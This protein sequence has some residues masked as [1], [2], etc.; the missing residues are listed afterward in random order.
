MTQQQTEVIKMELATLF[1][2][3]GAPEG[4]WIEVP[5]HRPD[6]HKS[7]PNYVFEP[8]LYRKLMMWI[9]GRG[10]KNRNLF[11]M[12]EAGV[13]KTSVLLEICYRLGIPVFSLSCSGDTK[14]RHLVGT[15][16]LKPDGSSAFVDGPLTQAL[17]CGGVFIGNEMT[18]MDPGQQMLFVDLLDD[19]GHL[20]IS[21]TGERLD[22]PP[23][24]RFAITGNSGGYGDMTGQYNGERVSSRAFITRF[25]KLV[26]QPMSLEQEVTMLKLAEP[27]LDDFWVQRMV[28][29]AR[30][31]RDGSVSRG[32]SLEVSISPRE[33]MYWANYTVQYQMINANGKTPICAN[34]VIEG[35]MDA[36]L[37]GAPEDQAATVLEIFN[38]WQ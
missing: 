10:I 31:I 16:E 19:G 15:V 36:V 28:E 22:V 20:T 27:A 30:R 2:G 25:M 12:G 3:C 24:F 9:R 21:E 38:N 17:R 26:V 11:L 8:T 14:F 32:G 7:K 37:N 1:P 18:R 4:V 23:G 5:A 33:L 13:G 6:L 29:F 35:L 34:P